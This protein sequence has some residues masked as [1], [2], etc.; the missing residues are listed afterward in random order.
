MRAPHVTSFLSELELSKQPELR[1]AQVDI[2]VKMLSALEGR[3]SP[4]TMHW[5]SLAELAETA[6]IEEATD[7]W[8]AAA[9]AV[10]D[11]FEPFEALAARRD[12][13]GLVRLHR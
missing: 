3:R 11:C 13:S 9:P 7:A 10:P 2:L 1:R 5:E 12:A 8:L 4:Q 6:V